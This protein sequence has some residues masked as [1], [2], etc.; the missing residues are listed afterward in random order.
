MAEIQAILD[1]TVNVTG[2]S[3]SFGYVDVDGKD[4]GLASGPKLPEF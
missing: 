1:D 2:Y 4:F 3:Y